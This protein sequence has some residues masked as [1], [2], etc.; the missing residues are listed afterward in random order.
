MK[1]LIFTMSLNRG[2]AERVIA[3]LCNECLVS[4]H[5]VTILTCCQGKSEY[6]LDKRIRHLCIDK[7]PEEKEENKIRR[8]VRRRKRLAEL[9]D[10]QKAD[11]MINILPE[12][13]FLALSLKEKYPIPMLVSVRSDPAREYNFPPYGWMMRRLYPKADGL[14]MQTEGARDYFPEKIRKKSV[15]IPNPIHR[16]AVRRPFRGER[17]KEI[18]AV[19]RL[20]EEKNYPML[21]EAFANIRREF[22]DYRLVI[23]GE[24][25]LREEL[26]AQIRKKNLEDRA[27]LAGQKEDIFERIYESRLFVM[28]SSHEGM[29]NALMEAMALGLPVIATDCPCG[30]PGFLI[31]NRKNGILIET[32]NQKALEGAVRE[33]LSDEELSAGLG[34][35]ACRIVE[36]LK[37]EK[38]YRQWEDYMFRITGEKRTRNE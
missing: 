15:V 26:Q 6:P 27:V 25:P 38:I 32:K 10:S 2:G 4:S 20:T 21:L 35:Q 16:D 29:P 37:P 23:Y 9:L 30:G 11:V 22:P 3:N 13:S 14:I 1:I 31:E 18:V 28:T 34:E 24:G 36:T 12:P 5:Q 8:F 7:N 17:K 19:G 33:L